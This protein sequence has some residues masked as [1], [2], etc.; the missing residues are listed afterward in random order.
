[1]HACN[2]TYF[3]SERERERERGGGGGERIKEGGSERDI[4]SQRALVCVFQG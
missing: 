2:L 4:W 1:M 3:K